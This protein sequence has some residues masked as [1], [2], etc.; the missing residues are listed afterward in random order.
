MDVVGIK[1]FLKL[2][3][4]VGSAPEQRT[5]TEKFNDIARC[6]C[7]NF[8]LRTT[9]G[10]LS[11]DVHL[12]RRC[13]SHPFDGQLLEASEDIDFSNTSNI[14]WSLSRCAMHWM[15]FH[16]I[17]IM[18]Y[19]PFYQYIL[20]V[21]DAFRPIIYHIAKCFWRLTCPTSHLLIAQDRVS[22]LP[23]E[24]TSAKH[25]VTRECKASGLHSLFT[26]TWEMCQPNQCMSLIYI[27]Q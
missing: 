26:I 7:K 4:N 20:Y 14:L 5:K 8:P 1:T 10:I 17:S 3:C 27:K 19:F 24:E 25:H 6:F 16:K 13:D 12:N 22:F 21:N 11:V 9:I 18:M 23:R 2:G 15:S